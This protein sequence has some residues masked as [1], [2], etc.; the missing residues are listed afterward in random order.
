MRVSNY[1]VM[2]MVCCGSPDFFSQRSRSYL[3][4][5][6]YL[7]GIDLDDLEPPPA[8]G[9]FFSLLFTLFKSVL[10]QEYCVFSA[11]ITSVVAV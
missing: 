10:W 4:R 7:D 11:G 5:L 3:T 6:G 9:M 8:D 1:Y 2:F